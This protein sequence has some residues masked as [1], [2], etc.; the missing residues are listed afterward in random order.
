M[1]RVVLFLVLL[2]LLAFG[3]AWVADQPG[4]V[5]IVWLGRHIEFEVLTGIVALVAAAAVAMALIAIAKWLLTSPAMARRAMRRRRARK[6]SEA[7]TRGILAVGAGDRRA[8]ERHAH[9]AEKFA[10]GQPLTLLLKAQTAQLS[11]DRGGAEQ[12]FRT[13]VET[14]ETRLLGLRGLYVEAQRRGDQ[15][16]A[17][18]IAEE[19][20]KDAPSA[21]WAS[22][23]VL[24]SQTLAGD[25]DGALTSIE[26]QYAARTIDREKAKRLRAVLL[27]AKAMAAEDHDPAGA[28]ALALEAHGL[29]PT[30]VPA[31]VVA[32]R[33]LAADGDARKASRVLEASW[34]ATPHPDIAEVFA[35][36]RRGDSRLDELKR[37]EHLARLVPS[38]PE[39][40]MAVARAAIDAGEFE[41]ARKALEPLVADSPTQRACLLMAELAAKDGGDHGRA[42]EWM[43]RALRAARDPV[44]TA[45]GQASDVW[46]PAS[47]VSGR[48]DAFEWKVPVAEIG[49]PVLQVDDVLAD[50][51]ESEQPA[52]MIEAPA[53]EAKTI[54]AVP[55]TPEV[56]PAPPA[57][58]VAAPAPA[59]A[60][61][62][63]EA[64]P[65]AP[66][67]L[68]S[69]PKPRP[70]PTETVF[71]I[72]RPPDDPG[73]DLAAKPK[74]ASLFG[75]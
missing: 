31:A 33:L 23:A 50:H 3:A 69:T 37:V 38:H 13:M 71:P 63:A 27:T 34:K 47:L 1:V 15:P 67:S 74:R 19:A 25:W 28:K 40:A 60:T 36:A 17:R 53:V 35:H 6:G 49:G 51:H 75:G 39:G 70:V 45:D 24:E 62:P 4:T 16:A 30:L 54:E 57:E 9:D 41:R 43:A 12:A 58:P 2:G 10:P 29:A 64:E 20:V 66:Q 56:I 65:A 21:A 22:Q 5:S 61:P 18:A 7:V 59:T 73:P 42:R 72:A 52:V 68:V 48:L 55:V 46:F 44:W 11:G 26:R 8:A 14:Q 32:G